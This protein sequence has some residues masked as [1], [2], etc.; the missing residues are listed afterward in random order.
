[1][2]YLCTAKMSSHQNIF[3]HLPLPQIKFGFCGVLSLELSRMG[4]EV[5]LSPPMSDLAFEQVCVALSVSRMEMPRG[6]P[7]RHI[8]APFVT[9]RS[10]VWGH[11]PVKRLFSQVKIVLHLKGSSMRLSLR[12]PSCEWGM[13]LADENIVST[14]KLTFRF[15]IYLYLYFTYI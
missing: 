3:K 1:M 9:G 5:L 15:C 14:G 4:E 2:T 12:I 6:P 8:V 13:F 7:G 11:G 10:S